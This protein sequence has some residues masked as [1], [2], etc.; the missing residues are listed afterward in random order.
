MS[1]LEASDEGGLRDIGHHDGSVARTKRS[2]AVVRLVSAIVLATR[3]FV[4]WTVVDDVSE[5]MTD[6]AGIVMI[7]GARAMCR[8]E[9][10]L[11]FVPKGPSQCMLIIDKSSLL[12][13]KL[14][15]VFLDLWLSR[16]T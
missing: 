6:S 2:L 9:A 5:E 4:S 3:A 15:E 14:V 12:L 10:S 1:F 13:R 11:F 8:V 7:F 16:D